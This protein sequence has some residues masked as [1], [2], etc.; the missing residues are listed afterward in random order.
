MLV[1]SFRRY[2]EDLTSKYAKIYKDQNIGKVVRSIR[3]LPKNEIQPY[4]LPFLRKKFHHLSITYDKSIFEQIR[5]ILLIE[6]L[7][8]NW[9]DF[10]SERYPESIQEQ[11][12]YNFQRFLKVCDHE[13]GWG[14]FE[15]N[16]YWKDLALARQQMFPIG[17]SRIVEAYSGFGL[18][19]GLG[20]NFFQNFNFLKILLLNRGRRGYYLV[21]LHRPDPESVEFSEQKRNESY[22]RIAQMLK[23]HSKVKGLLSA[24]WMYDPQLAEISPRLMYLQ[25]TPL[26]N[27]AETFYVS[28][29][30]SGNALEKSKTRKELNE[31]GMYIP[32]IYLVIWPREALIRWASNLPSFNP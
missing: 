2:L 16:I 32:K 9:N 11:F 31:K 17:G 13:K 3:D 26:E 14:S 22:C 21:H 23:I 6:I 4:K 10:F 24:S 12:K 8:S 15:E 19:D 30:Y 29:D 5:K 27:G 18:R 1:D 20:L 25:E 28:V 7:V